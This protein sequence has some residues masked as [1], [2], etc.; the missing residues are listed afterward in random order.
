MEKPG[1]SAHFPKKTG[2]TPGF[3]RMS[4]GTKSNCAFNNSGHNSK[5]KLNKKMKILHFLSAR[6][7]FPRS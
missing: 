5:T 7:E 1:S 3:F 4:A 2:C 6:E